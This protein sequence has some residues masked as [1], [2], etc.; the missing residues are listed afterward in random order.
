[1]TPEEY[2]EKIIK[3]WGLKRAGLYYDLIDT[4]KEYAEQKVNEFRQK[5]IDE[6]IMMITAAKEIEYEI[7]DVSKEK[8]KG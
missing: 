4:L 2:A 6:C 7:M 8:S 1:M 3:D 5:L